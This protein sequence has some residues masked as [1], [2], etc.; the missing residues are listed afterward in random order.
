MGLRYWNESDESG[1]SIWRFE[2]LDKQVILLL[3]WLWLFVSLRGIYNVHAMTQGK[4]VFEWT[5]Q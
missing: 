1:K 5:S 2:S 3:F 4:I